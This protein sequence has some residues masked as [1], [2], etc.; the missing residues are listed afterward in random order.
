M[1]MQAIL[2]RISGWRWPVL[3]ILASLAMLGAAHFF[4]RAMLLAPCPLCLK[5]R[6][7]YWAVVAMAI[8]GLALWRWQ[9]T[10]RFLMAFNLLIG[11][12]FLVGAVV[13]FYH[14]GVEYGWFSAPSGCAAG[15]SRETIISGTIDIDQPVAIASCTDT[16]WSFLGLSM[17]AWNGMAS[18]GLAGLSFL[19]ARQTAFMPSER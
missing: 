17:A 6:E 18:L 11:L 15:A 4:E 13:A 12:A 3:A 8:T 9:P 19:A 16:L 10:R 2:N 5:Q 7:V 1:A 14:M